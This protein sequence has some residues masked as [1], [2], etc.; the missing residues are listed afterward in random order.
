MADSYANRR[1]D[2]L[3]WAWKHKKRAATLAKLAMA[4]HAADNVDNL[5]RGAAGAAASAF[6]FGVKRGIDYAFGDNEEPVKK[7]RRVGPFARKIPYRI[8]KMG[9]KRYRPRY[10]RPRR[11]RRFR[12]RGYGRY[13]VT[14]LSRQIRDIRKTMEI[15][16]TRTNNYQ[17]A[18]RPIFSYGQAY[19]KPTAN[20]SWLHQI[21]LLHGYQP[22]PGAGTQSQR[23][24]LSITLTSIHFRCILHSASTDVFIR[25]ALIMVRNCENRQQ[26]SATYPGIL[27]HAAD[28]INQDEYPYLGGLWNAPFARKAT[29]RTPSI[30]GEGLAL[31]DIKVLRHGVITMPSYKTVA[32]FDIHHRWSAGFR[33][34]MTFANDLDAQNDYAIVKNY[35]TLLMWTNEDSDGTVNTYGDTTDW[36]GTATPTTGAW[37]TDYWG[38]MTY[39]DN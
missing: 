35:P 15:R 33:P 37:I 14:K 36:D 26:A 19:N 28:L 7:W 21:P 13:R 4:K 32:P 3:K 11:R 20:A 18:L 10:R 9:Y 38:R 24:G 29:S 30:G 27:A 23:L 5:G 8:G 39:V 22:I 25:W 16:F 31:G 6:I 34:I 17:G 12:K 2:A 1:R